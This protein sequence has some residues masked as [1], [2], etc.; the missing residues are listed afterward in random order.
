[1][2]DQERTIDALD[3]LATLKMRGNNVAARSIDSGYLIDNIGNLH[4]V[5]K[6]SDDNRYPCFQCSCW[7]YDCPT[8]T[9]NNGVCLLEVG[10]VFAQMS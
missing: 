3:V 9:A 1:M 4:R 7:G 8:S 2:C 10:F 5:V 6:C